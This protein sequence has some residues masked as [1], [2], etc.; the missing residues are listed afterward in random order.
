MKYGLIFGIAL[1]LFAAG[2]SKEHPARTAAEHV[3]LS[4]LLSRLTNVSIFAEAPLG[5]S[6]LVSSYDRSGGNQDWLVYPKTMAKGPVTIFEA[7]GPGYVSRF[8]IATFAAERW[9]FY[10]DGESEPRLDLAKDDLFGDCFPFLPPLSGMSGGGRYSLMPIPF[11]KSLRIEMVPKETLNPNNRNYIQINYT[12]L[13]VAPEN[14]E[15]FP[16]ALSAGESNAVVAVNA[17]FENNDDALR[18]V[19]EVALDGV[20]SV[21][22]GA[23]EAVPFWTDDGAGVLQSFCVRID[24]PSAGEAMSLDLLRKLRLRFYWDGAKEPSVDVPLGDFFCNPYYFRSYSS[25]PLGRIEDAF[26]CRFPMPYQRGARCEIRN[27]S[28]APVSLSIGAIG[29]KESA[30]GLNRRFHARWNASTRSGRP[31]EFV[32]VDG[33]GHFVGCFLSAIGQDGTWTM[34]EGD[35]FLAPDAGEQP[36]QLGTGLE[37]YFNGAYY[38]TS[39]FDLPFHGLIEKGGDA[40]GSVSSAYA[41]CGGV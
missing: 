2:C 41:R 3:D 36:P 5:E 12:K 31:M 1:M 8:W 23:G 28:G 13:D 26:I 35:E 20:D 37:D 10:F 17:A 22:I 16:R 27:V 24:D 38:Y 6:F 11:S 34:L 14:V 29:D 18:Q 30:G 39:L 33:A 15:S 32:T 25:L 21:M 9:R 19:A 40:D 4:F 7:E